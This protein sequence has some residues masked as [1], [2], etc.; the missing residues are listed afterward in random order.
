MRDFAEIY[1]IAAERKGGEAAL[2]TMLARPMATEQLA[3]TKDDRWL[4]TMAKC[5]FQAGFNWKVIEAK[6]QGFEE[7]FDG[8]VPKR[9]AFY[10]GE[11]V[12]RLLSDKRIVRNG[13]KIKAVVEN[14]AFLVELADTHG[15]A[16]RFF[17]DWPDDDYVGLLAFLKKR[18]SRLGGVTGQRVLRSMGKDSFILS[19]DVTAR[20]IAEGV[21]AKAP[22][23]KRD[24]T[25]VQEA[26]NLWRKESGR[27]LTEISRVLAMSVGA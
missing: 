11:T 3:E 10:D 14:A 20:L 5:L 4:S 21:V 1:R 6:W 18:G 16:A 22:S 27:S 7:A 19:N 2:E 12:D 23:S 8:F 15:S 17:A 9:V 26:F 13:A 24:M 25:A